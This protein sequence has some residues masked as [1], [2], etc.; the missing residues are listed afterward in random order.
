M[1]AGSDAVE[2]VFA[3][4]RDPEIY[5]EG[6]PKELKFHGNKYALHLS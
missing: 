5:E 1:N 6:N 2:E 3:A 4:S